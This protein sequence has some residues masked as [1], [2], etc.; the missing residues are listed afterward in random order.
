M[1][2]LALPFFPFKSPLCRMSTDGCAKRAFFK[3]PVFDIPLQESKV[4]QRKGGPMVKRF[5]S[6][7]LSVF[8]CVTL[9]L[10]CTPNKQ[11]MQTAAPKTEVVD[12]MG[13]TLQLP[14]EIRRLVVLSAAEAEILCELGAQSLLVGRGTYCNYPASLQN[15]QEVASGSE[16]NV[17]EIIALNPDLVVLNSMDQSK[18]V[19]DLIEKSGICTL[20]TTATDIEGVYASIRMLGKAL[21]LSQKAEET[22][23]QMQTDFQNLPDISKLLPPEEEASIY[24]EISPLEWG[25]W[26]SGNHTF[27]QEIAAALGL[28]N[29]FADVEGWAQVS[30]EQV[31]A[32]NPSIILSLTSKEMLGKDPVEEITLRESWQTLSAVQN[33]RVFYYDADALSRPGPRL[34]KAAQGLADTIVKA[35]T[36]N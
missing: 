7:I 15:I 29:L 35:L 20:V 31:L 32:R 26:S 21:H 18:E 5:L 6:S 11:A 27:Y 33:Q 10:G 25:L 34:A 22:V 8:L 14:N 3:V 30:E 36:E 13:R 23:L 28:K 16:T 9:L 12:G 24:F 2:F 4:L 19:V 17:E 1:P